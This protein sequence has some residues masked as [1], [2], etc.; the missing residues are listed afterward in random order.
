MKAPIGNFMVKIPWKAP[1]FNEI[2]RLV[3]SCR[4]RSTGCDNIAWF[5]SDLVITAYMCFQK[6]KSIGK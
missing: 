5:N 1:D 4:S 2:C 3:R 6:K